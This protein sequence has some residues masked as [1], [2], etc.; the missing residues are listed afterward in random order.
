MYRCMWVWISMSVRALY[1]GVR[2]LSIQVRGLLR[3]SSIGPQ[4]AIR[5]SVASLWE[6]RR[7]LHKLISPELHRP[8]ALEIMVFNC[9]Q[10]IS[11]SRVAGALP[12]DAYYGVRCC[13]LN[14]QPI[15][16]R[17][18][19]TYP[20]GWLRRLALCGFIFAI[21]ADRDDQVSS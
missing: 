9:F 15:L 17:H 1:P 18:G 2:G 13:F 16:D 19:R 10:L 11:Y 12:R 21:R 8:E 7:A 20:W 3:T 4:L 5:I 14:K 6:I